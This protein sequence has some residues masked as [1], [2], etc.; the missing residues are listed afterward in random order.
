MRRK[1]PQEPV[2]ARLV[3]QD[4][5]K[6]MR[7]SLRPDITFRQWIT[8]GQSRIL[9]DP[10]QLRYIVSNLCMNAQ[11][12]MEMGKGFLGVSLKQT[13]IAE[14][15]PALVSDLAPGDYVQLTV[16]DTGSGI[17]PEIMDRIFDPFFTTGQSGQKTGLGLSV[18]YAVVNNARGSIMV[19]SDPGKG[20]RFKIFFPLW[21]GD[22]T[23]SKRP[24]VSSRT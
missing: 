4:A 3:V 11:E 19:Q 10:T 7:R 20:T 2:D 13:R 21:S 12:A 22:V 18:V 9:V 24:C 8:C 17:N 14:T 5:L 16:R 23:S 15:T 6:V 1:D